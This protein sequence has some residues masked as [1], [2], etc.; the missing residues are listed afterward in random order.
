M[1]C[2]NQCCECPSFVSTTKILQVGTQL[3]LVLN[4]TT[5][6]F[7]NEKLCVAF[8]QNVPNLTGIPS[9][10]IVIGA[11]TYPIIET[12]TC[13]AHLLYADQ[14][15]QCNG[16][17]ANRQMLSLKYS[18]DLGMFVFCGNRRLCK[19]NAV[20]ESVTPANIS[21]DVTSKKEK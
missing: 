12:Q 10:A 4:G 20:V 11:T 17:V 14:L 7:N 21:T 1:N 6:L 8:A 5:N 18:A 16:G 13:G 15:K 9:V 2:Q 19:T 3:E